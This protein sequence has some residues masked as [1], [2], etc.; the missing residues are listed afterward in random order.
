MTLTDEQ[1]KKGFWYRRP[2]DS[3]PPAAVTYPD[4][5]DGGERLN[6]MCTQFDIPAYQQRKLVARWVEVLPT[7][8]KLRCLWLSSRVGQNLFEAACELSG[9]TGLYVKWS[10]IRQVDSILKLSSLQ[11]LHLGSSSQVSSVECLS[12]LTNL[13]V[14]ELENLK[15]M[16]SLEGV[17]QLDQLEGLSVEGSTWTTQWVDSLKP[18]ARLRNLKYLF[19]TNLKSKDGTLQPLTGL[20]GLVN[21]RV[22]YWWPGE[23]YALLRGALPNLKYGSVFEPELIERFSK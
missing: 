22:A 2:E 23:E 18:L 16:H 11:Y 19:M 1:I 10:G 9:L 21:L 7:L 17:G 12:Q 6:L 3:F 5:Y 13:A 15:P 8:K 4:E 20:T 14:L